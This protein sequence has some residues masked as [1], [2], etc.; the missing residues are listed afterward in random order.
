MTAIKLH[1]RIRNKKNNFFKADPHLSGMKV[2]N[3]LAVE[4]EKPGG[5]PYNFGKKKEYLL[6]FF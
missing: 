6:I 5:I 4:T 3:R 1:F 2:F